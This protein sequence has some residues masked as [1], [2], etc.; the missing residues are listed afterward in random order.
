MLRIEFNK[1]ELSMRHY[2]IVLHIV[3]IMTILLIHGCCQPKNSS[4]LYNI[5]LDNIVNR[6]IS[7]K[8]LQLDTSFIQL[9]FTADTTKFIGTIWDMAF[10]SDDKLYILEQQTSYIYQ[11]D[12]KSGEYINGL[13]N[14]GRG[15]NEH[16][17]IC[18]IDVDKN[19]L[20]L[21]DNMRNT[22]TVYDSLLNRVTD[23][24]LP[25]KTLAFSVIN[26]TLWGRG[27]SIYNGDIKIYC[28]NLQ[29]Q[30]I[31]E[32][33]DGLNMSNLPFSITLGYA[34]TKHNSKIYYIPDFKNTIKE[35]TKDSIYTSVNIDFNTYNI[36][37]DDQ[38]KEITESKAAMYRG[39]ILDNHILFSYHLHKNLNVCLYNIKDKTSIYG[40]IEYGKNELPFLI[41]WQDNNTL[42]GYHS[43][44][45]AT[46][47]KGMKLNEGDIVIAFMKKSS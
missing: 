17:D 44:T 21:L 25:L 45:S 8:E 18:D 31:S 41:R 13:F 30:I 38:Y 27:F 29:G 39:F 11:F 16:I 19:R 26:D 34:F 46:V 35:L 32:F 15:P 23:F 10:D 22:I 12:K 1:K 2:N 14:I 37:P 6:T 43:A 33:D 7:S 28:C 40:I 4:T 9:K 47:Y 3:A 36:H 42:I 24:E 20:Y 5:E